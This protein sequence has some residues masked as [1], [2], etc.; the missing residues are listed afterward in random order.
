MAGLKYPVNLL[1]G[2]CA[3]LV[4]CAAPATVSA[5]FTYNWGPLT[6]SFSSNEARCNVSGYSNVNCTT[7]QYSNPDPSRFVQETI[8]EGG[9]NYY[10]VVV[11]DPA[12]GFA[13][14]VYIRQGG[15]TGCN[16][17]AQ[18]S[19][20]GSCGN[21]SNVFSVSSG[22]TSGSGSGTARPTYTVMKQVLSDGE[23]N[24]VFFKD[25][26]DAKP[27]ITQDVVNAD[28][29]MRFSIDM[30]NS[31]YSTNTTAG[32]V[33]NSLTLLDPTLGN[34][35]N[36]DFA[37]DNQLSTVTGGRYTWVTGSGFNTSYGTY[38]YAVGGFSVY[39][40]DWSKYRIAGQNPN[41]GGCNGT[42]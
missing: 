16:G 12:A 6:T 7:N 14:E 31:N 39:S 20:A 8:S 5:A 10:H 18:S 3:G 27:L 15:G 34:A 38:T 37:T 22:T 42:C 26:L 17:F 32:V 28:I 30:R 4:W 41:G 33:T 21:D 40:V 13:S 36:Y 9:A 35:G 1:F 23:I 24:S 25:G 11:G 19:S 2:L 29:D